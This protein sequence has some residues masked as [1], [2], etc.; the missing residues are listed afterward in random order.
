[1]GSSRVMMVVDG[2]VL[3]AFFW[4]VRHVFVCV[5]RVVRG[6]REASTEQQHAS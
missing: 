4:L 3:S 1:M 2:H 5:E 6:R